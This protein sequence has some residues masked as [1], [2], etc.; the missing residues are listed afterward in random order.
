MGA[1]RV[2]IIGAGPAG[3]FLSRLLGQTWPGARID[4]YERSE[5]GGTAG[6]GIALSDRTMR[7]LAARDSLV[8]DRIGRLARPLSGVELRMPGGRLRYDGFPVV[9][10]SRGAVLAVLTEEARAVGVRVHH[11][12]DARADELDADLVVLADGARSTHRTAR[13]A[14]FGTTVRTGAARYIWLG[15]TADVGDAATMFFVPTEHGPMAAH[16]YS[17]GG[18]LSTV[19]VEL[20]DGTWRR[21]GLDVAC[22]AD[23]APG[24]IGAAGLALLDDVFAGQ[25]GAGLVS[26]R[27]RWSRFD[28]VT[29]RRWSDGNRVLIGDAAHT[30]HF[31]V[32]SGTTMALA[33]AMALAGALREHDT[34]TAAFDAYERERRPAVARVQRLAGPSM[35]WWETYGRR[36][37]LPP[38]Q[39]G[40]HFITRTTAISYHGL[41]RRCPTRIAEAEAAYRRTDGADPDAP[42]RHAVAEPFTARGSRLPHRLVGV[43]ASAPGSSGAG[44]DVPCL[45]P[46]ARLEPLPGG[47]RQGGGEWAAGTQGRLLAPGPYPLRFVAL[48]APDPAADDDALREVAALRRRGV[49][50]VLLLPGRAG[51]WDRIVEFGGRVRT[52]V[53][54]VVAGCV[55][56][57][58]STDLCRD[59]AVDA[60]PTRIHLA[61]VSA[62]LDLVAQWPRRATE[63]A[64]PEAPDEL[65]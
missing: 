43:G 9:A 14:A 3:L 1:T 38:A 28:V 50:G 34:V 4:V 48:A 51:W 52:E 39:F 15:T 55:P 29:N 5:P 40:M 24:E 36:M 56:M 45:V 7:Q 32:A 13:A 33:D 17:C 59:P 23:G 21:A 26:N 61:L 37:H 58:W 65:G 64:P 18:G 12:H 46:A 11:G 62:R 49:D 35:R 42:A 53:G 54:V 8:A 41:R 22:R 31:A 27:S 19:V 10:V 30:A 2:A 57:D 44:A 60:W 16:A 20:D 6:F 63:L 25:L 47:P